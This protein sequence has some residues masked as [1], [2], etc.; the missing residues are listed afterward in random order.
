MRPLVRSLSLALLLV[1]SAPT[2]A[3]AAAPADGIGAEFATLLERA[4]AHRVF[5]VG[6]IHG[7]R[8]IQRHFGELAAAL[9][10]DGGPLIVGL[11]IWR[12]EQPALDRYLASAGTG[13][14]R[15]RL[16]EA[17]FWTIR[18]G[19]SSEAMVDLIERL[20]VLALKAPLRVL[21]FD[22]DPDSKV[23]GAARD[24]QMGEA[25]NAALEAHPQ[26]RLLVLAGNFHTRLQAGAPWDPEYRFA[27]HYLQAHEPYAVEI[28]PASGSAWM[29][30]GPEGCR[31]WQFQ[32]RAFS[33]GLE[34]GEAL[35]DRRHHGVW[36]MPTTASPPASG[37]D[38][39]L[40]EPQPLQPPAKQ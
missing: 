2:L 29:C 9:A 24:R 23:R 1:V 4:R 21:A 35:N 38:P 8:E 22:V 36:R 30:N 20:R 39:G 26:A 33:V 25:L 16:L 19:R 40:M 10:G 13:E 3:A 32:D 27:G 17:S 15:A 14:D 34:L 18:D 5:L 28:M 6:E 37:A 12:S 11:E 7:T 31:A